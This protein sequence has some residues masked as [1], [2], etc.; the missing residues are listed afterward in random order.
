[1]SAVGGLGI[2]WHREGNR[3]YSVLLVGI[4]D[5]ER[6]IIRNRARLVSML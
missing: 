4:R 6:E 1:M 2:Y 3:D 5:V